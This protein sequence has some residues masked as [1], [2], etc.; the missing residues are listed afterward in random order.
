MGDV[1]LARSPRALF[2]LPGIA[3]L[4]GAAGVVGGLILGGAAA[5]LLVLIG[6]LLLAAGLAAGVLLASVQ[7]A[8]EPGAV[9]VRWL[10]GRR[11]YPLAHGELTRVGRDPSGSPPMRVPLGGFGMAFGPGTFHGTTPVTVVSL[12]VSAPLIVIPTRR[13]ALAVAPADEAALLTALREAAAL[14]RRAHARVAPIHERPLTGIERAM[15][16][17]ARHAEEQA[18]AQRAAAASTTT[19]G[20]APRRAL[21]QDWGAAVGRAATR[22]RPL[23]AGARLQRARGLRPLVDTGVARVRAA[24]APPATAASGVLRRMRLNA[25]QRMP[26]DAYRGSARAAA[27]A[28]AVSVVPTL[29]AVAIALVLLGPLHLAQV[30]AAEREPLVVALALGGPGATAASL[31]ARFGWPRLAG[32]VAIS[33]I[34]GLLIAVRA[35]FV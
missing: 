4:G 17:E 15:L 12:D 16:E 6:V 32:L 33:G 1:R 21:G 35:A 27:P 24:A 22:L 26:L 7:V 29:V 20:P 31:L 14:G 9:V 28:L 8:V 10:G 13:G 2:A 30:D 11:R 18:A 34:F 5:M 23:V 19:P 3:I 25:T